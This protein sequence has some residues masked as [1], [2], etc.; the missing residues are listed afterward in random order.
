MPCL[1]P[2]T[3]YKA[4]EHQV[5]DTGTGRVHRTQVP[6]GRCR[7]CRALYKRDWTGRL[8]AEATSAVSTLFVTLTYKIEPAEFRP[9]YRD[10]QLMLKQVREWLRVQHGAHLRFFCAGERGTKGNRVHWH[11]LF[12]VDKRVFWPIP[13]KG[14]LWQF[15]PHGWASLSILHGTDILQKIRYTVKYMCK[16]LGEG[17]DAFMRCSLKPGIGHEYLMRYARNIAESGLAPLGH[18]QV[19]G[20]DIKGVPVRHRLTGA[21]RRRFIAAWRERWME[22][23]PQRDMPCNAWLARYDPEMPIPIR[24]VPFMWRAKGTKWKRADRKAFRPQR[25]PR[26]GYLLIDQGSA[27][28]LLVVDQWGRAVIEWNNV[29][30]EVGVDI[31]EVIRLYPEDRDYI[32]A[33]LIA[34]RALNGVANVETVSSAE[35]I[36]R[37][38][39]ERRERRETVRQHAGETRKR[40]VQEHGAAPGSGGFYDPEQQR[41]ALRADAGSGQERG[42]AARQVVPCPF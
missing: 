21:T 2:Y 6:C 42:H 13:K 10:V 12:F 5:L 16:D 14:E 4:G 32:N 26:T 38:V 17:N 28:A 29:T 31:G 25:Q 22:V 7:E 15:W 40:L 36:A 41:F 20:I 1:S 3:L 30:H 23:R 9:A 34:K 33:W 37:R 35:I 18:F 19:G 11:I 8:T 24:G 27:R 39:Q